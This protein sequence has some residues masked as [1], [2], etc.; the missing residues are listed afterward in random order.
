MKEVSPKELRERNEK[1]WKETQK[2]FRRRLR[3]IATGGQ[4]NATYKMDDYCFGERIQPWLESLGFRVK[5]TNLSWYEVTWSEEEGVLERLREY[6]P[7]LN[8][9]LPETA[10]R[11]IDRLKVKQKELG[12]WRP[13]PSCYD[14]VCS[15][16]GKHSEY[17]TDFCC[18]CGKRMII[19]EEK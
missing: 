13:D 18:N 15:A 12:T 5:P 19:K 16:C 8:N 9:S 1:S 6:M 3:E 2:I 14:Y 17:K 4:H 10:R 7:I 11:A